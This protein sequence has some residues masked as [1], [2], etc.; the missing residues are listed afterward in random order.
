MSIAE[1]GSHRTGFMPYEVRPL[2]PDD[3][4]AV[5]AVER[6]VFPTTW[7]PTPFKKELNNRLAHYLVAWDPEGLVQ[8]S[9]APEETTSG[10]PS[11]SASTIRSFTNAS[12]P[13]CR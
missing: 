5:S 7:P 6:E 8:T 9:S 4:P 1:H 13:I 10:P 3:I 12:L 11:S 2:T